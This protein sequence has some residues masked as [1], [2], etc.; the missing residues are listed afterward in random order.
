MLLKCLIAVS[1]ENY[2][3]GRLNMMETFGYSSDEGQWLE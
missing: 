3:Y 1:I 2:N